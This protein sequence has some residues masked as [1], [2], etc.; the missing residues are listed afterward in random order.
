M[1]LIKPGRDTVKVDD[2]FSEAGDTIEIQLDPA[3]N[4]QD[5]AKR[6]YQR[7]AKAERAEK[8]IEQRHKDLQKE[9]AAIADLNSEFDAASEDIKALRKLHGRLNAQQLIPSQRRK[10]Q[11]KQSSRKP[12]RRFIHTNGAQLIVGRNNTDNDSVTFQVGNDLDFWLHAA[13]IPGSHVI[14]RNPQRRDEPLAHHL[15]VAA[16]VAA[17]YSKARNSANVQVHWTQRR[18]IKKLK[19][20][21][22]GQVLLKNY[23][24]VIADPKLPNGLEMDE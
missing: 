1:H 20:G 13:G 14:L 19:G 3:L 15:S 22:P 12:G 6:Y 10:Q 8:H 4:G 23:K 11:R 18:F 9:S 5:N 17:Y 2:L 24:S 7:A 21:N 16:S